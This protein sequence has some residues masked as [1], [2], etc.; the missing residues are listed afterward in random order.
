MNPLGLFVLA[1][2]SLTD[3]PLSVLGRSELAC[4]VC[5]HAFMTVVSAQANTRGGVDRDLFARAL[6]PQPVYY[7]I[8]TCPKCGY[9]G[10]LADFDPAVILPPDVRNQVLKEPRL[11]LPAEFTPQSDPREL[12]AANRY[13]LAITCYHWRQ[14][15]D[16]ALAW[17]H[18]RASWVARDKGAIL[19]RD[20]RL[21]RVM[22]YIE[23]WRPRLRPNENQL[24]VE[25]KLTTRVAEA[26]ATGQF[27]RYQKPYVELALALILRRHGENCRAQ[28]MLDRLVA[29]ERFS[30]PLRQGIQRMR[31]SV[32][33][34]RE[35]QIA[36][37]RHFESALWANQ[38]SGSN[39]ASARYV[40]GELCRR[41]GRDDE[42]LQWFDKAL[43]DPTLAVEL[44]TWALQQRVWCQS[45]GEG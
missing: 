26:L 3:V 14:K 37:A 33:K 45:P 2:V 34:E 10:Y 27:N 43:S 22:K 17:L 39:R 32:T 11:P 19:P 12:D 25:M 5:R 9:S 16:E 4:P 30:D 13:N 38:V 7:Q 24:D 36:A 23:R 18:L 28:P 20:G 15:S 44:R 29:Y 6:G 21:A 1:V 31:E 8:S 42:A 41:L 40:L 35:H